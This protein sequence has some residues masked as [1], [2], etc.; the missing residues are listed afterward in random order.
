MGLGAIMVYRCVLDEYAL[1]NLQARA[2]G[3]RVA[4]RRADAESC[5]ADRG[6]LGAIGTRARGARRA[7]ETEGRAAAVVAGRSLRFGTWIG[8]LSVLRSDDLI[9]DYTGVA[10]L[11]AAGGVGERFER[12][13]GRLTWPA[14]GERAASSREQCPAAN[15]RTRAPSSACACAVRSCWIQSRAPVRVKNS[16]ARREPPRVS[17]SLTSNVGKRFNVRSAG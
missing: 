4:A 11:A 12:L 15:R 7:A 5:A 10:T 8:A 14:E 9:E 13:W 1:R 17:A 3:R 2:D 6:G 16:R